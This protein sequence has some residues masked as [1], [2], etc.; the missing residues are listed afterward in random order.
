MVTLWSVVFLLLNV[1]N[2]GREPWITPL[3]GVRVEPT[4]PMRHEKDFGE[5]S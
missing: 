2:D 3:P 4:R 1:I 5:D